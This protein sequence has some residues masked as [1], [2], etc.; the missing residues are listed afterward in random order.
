MLDNKPISFSYFPAERQNI[1][2]T[3]C[4]HHVILVLSA[5]TQTNIDSSHKLV[6]TR[7]SVTTLP[8]KKEKKK[9]KRL[10]E[11]GLCGDPDSCFFIMEHFFQ[12]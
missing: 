3:L 7:Q 9:I 11:I 4:D 8:K 1:S 12:M 6:T 2:P 10:R 5:L